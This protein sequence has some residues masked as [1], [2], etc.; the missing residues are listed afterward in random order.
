[1]TG[2]AQL[3]AALYPKWQDQYAIRDWQ[4][5]LTKLTPDEE[6]QFQTWAKTNKAPITDDYDMRGFWKFGG[7]TGVSKNDGMMHYT[8]RYKTPLHQSFSGESI[9]ADPA[10]KP[11]SWNDKDQLVASDGTILFDERRKRKAR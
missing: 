6:K 1:M 7:E 5:R 2:F 8:D 11:P 4:S 10:T 3:A 9:Y